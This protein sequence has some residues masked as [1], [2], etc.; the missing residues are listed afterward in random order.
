MEFIRL[1]DQL[2]SKSQLY[3]NQYI[4]TAMRE[5]TVESIQEAHD[6]SLSDNSVE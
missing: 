6:E 1:N 5:R 4:P 3:K 2:S